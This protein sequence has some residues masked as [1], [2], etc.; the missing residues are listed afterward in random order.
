MSFINLQKKIKKK[1]KR[2]LFDFSSGPDP[3]PDPLSRNWICIKMKRIRKTGYRYLCKYNLLPVS[4]LDFL[5]LLLLVPAVLLL[6]HVVAL[7]L[8]IY[9]D[10]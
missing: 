1:T 10:R 6:A 9:V 4:L 5:Q 7:A 8:D 3:E 2:N